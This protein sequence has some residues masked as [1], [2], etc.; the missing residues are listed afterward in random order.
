MNRLTKILA[1]YGCLSAVAATAQD[2]TPYQTQALAGI[3]K[4]L[5]KYYQEQYYNCVRSAME[6]CR[7]ARVDILKEVLASWENTPDYGKYASKVMTW[8]RKLVVTLADTSNN[9]VIRH[10]RLDIPG[11][12]KEIRDMMLTDPASKPPTEYI[13]RHLFD[14]PHLYED[15]GDHCK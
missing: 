4:A 9:Y 13:C 5:T 8:H 11:L 15:N 3:K 7:M 10:G 6:A 2:L 12:E 1:L 14:V